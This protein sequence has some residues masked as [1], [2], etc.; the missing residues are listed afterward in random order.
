MG[1]VADGFDDLAGAPVLG[2]YGGGLRY[3]IF[4][5]KR[6]MIRIDYGRGNDDGAL[7]FSVNEAF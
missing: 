7:Y 2:S 6:L 3:K 1:T 4:K 5:D